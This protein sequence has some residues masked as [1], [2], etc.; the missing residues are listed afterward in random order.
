MDNSRI[1]VRA[2]IAP[3]LAWV[4]GLMLIV[5]SGQLVSPL[6]GRAG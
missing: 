6:S 3:G 5:I 2:F 1:N 4:A